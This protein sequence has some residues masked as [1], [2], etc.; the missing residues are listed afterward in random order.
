MLT[1]TITRLGAQCEQKDTQ[2]NRPYSHYSTTK[3]DGQPQHYA[4]LVFLAL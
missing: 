3:H 4:I 1:I 2:A